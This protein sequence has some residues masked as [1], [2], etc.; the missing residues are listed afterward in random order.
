MNPDLKADVQ[1]LRRVLLSLVF[2]TTLSGAMVGYTTVHAMNQSGTS[3]P[4]FCNN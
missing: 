1:F 3:C 4:V 2:L